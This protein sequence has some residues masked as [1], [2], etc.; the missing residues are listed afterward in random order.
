M[1]FRRKHSLPSVAFATSCWERDWR[2]I[3]LD[4][5]YLASKQIA[6]HCF[7]FAEKILV[8][9]NVQDLEAVLTAA[10]QRIADGVLTRLIVAEEEAPQMLAAF[11][12]KRED[13]KVGPD[14]LFYENVNSDWIYYNALGPLTAIYGSTSD[15]LLYLTG[16]VRLDEPLDWIGKAIQLM[17]KNPRYK[18]ANPLWN[19]RREEAKREAQA[20]R[21]GFYVS[22]SGFS[23]QLFLVKRADF[24]APIYSEIREDA[25]H[26]PRGDV[27]EKRVFS[28]MR[29]RGWLRLTYAKG[30]YTHENF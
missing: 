6:N 15:Y 22:D 26:F 13:F 17:E 10:T 19:G 27:F 5:E 7:S 11:G 25:A 8:I 14:A 21:R 9:N 1:L 29:N 3:L 28:A 2:Q 24:L 16:D 23:D 18:V 12:L 30:S 4:P 20:R